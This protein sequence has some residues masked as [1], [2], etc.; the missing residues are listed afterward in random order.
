[1]ILLRIFFVFEIEVLGF[2]EALGLDSSRVSVLLNILWCCLWHG[3]LGGCPKISPKVSCCVC[4]CVLK[5]LRKA[6]IYRS[7]GVG[8]WHVVKF[9]WWHVSQSDWRG[10]ETF[11]LRHV[12]SFDWPKC[13]DFQGD[14]CQHPIGLSASSLTRA[15]LLMS[16]LT[17]TDVS[18]VFACILCPYFNNTWQIYVGF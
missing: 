1:M 16:S 8:E 2:L 4:V 11:S 13:F 14:T 10:F 12:A 9:D 18:L 3:S 15:K 5:C 17:P 6:F 7:L